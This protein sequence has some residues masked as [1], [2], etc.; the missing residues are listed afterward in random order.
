MMTHGRR[1]D[2]WVNL[3]E[4]VYVCMDMQHDSRVDLSLD[5]A[6]VQDLRSTIVE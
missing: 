6:L 4:M 1:F 2:S 5:T 3:N